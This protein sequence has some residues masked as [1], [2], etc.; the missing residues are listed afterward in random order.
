MALY[1]VSVLLK[2]SGYFLLTIPNCYRLREV[3]ENSESRLSY[4]NN[5]FNIKFDKIVERKEWKNFGIKYNFTLQDAV[6]E[7]P[8]YVVD[9]NVLVRC[10]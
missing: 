3:I 8:E 9:W 4:G 1:N 6:D 2:M 10:Y 7:C 5:L